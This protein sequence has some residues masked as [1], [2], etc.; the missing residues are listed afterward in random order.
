MDEI[1]T[2]ATDSA[3]PAETS[4]PVEGNVSSDVQQGSQSPE[5]GSPATPPSEFPS[6]EEFA[7][8]QASER[9]SNWQRARARIDELNAQNSE[10]QPLTGFLQQYGGQPTI[11]AKVGFVDKLWTPAL[12]DNGQPY[13]DPNTGV[14]ALTTQPFI[15]ELFSSSPQTGSQLAWELMDQQLQ[16]GQSVGAAWMQHRLGLDPSKYELYKQISDGT[17]SGPIGNVDQ[18]ELNAIAPEFHDAY[19]TWNDERRL[20]FWNSPE[21]VQSQLLAEGK[22]ALDAEKF[23][24]EQRNQQAQAE[25]QRAQQQ[26]QARQRLVEQRGNA[27][28][29]AAWQQSGEWFAQE[30]AKPIEMLGLDPEIKSDISQ[31]ISTKVEHTIGNDPKTAPIVAGITSNLKLAEEYASRGDKYRAQA[32]LTSAQ[33]AMLQLRPMALQVAKKH[34]EMANKMFSGNRAA[35]A[36]TN[37]TPARTEIA[38][39]GSSWA[40]E[41]FNPNKSE[42]H[43]RIADLVAEFANSGR[44]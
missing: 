27:R 32:S 21:S 7:Q 11:E 4:S 35:L 25:Q 13:V 15:Q 3:A 17:F 8:L 20:A 37:N 5:S 16:N 29:E 31:W 14:P 36:Q 23:I 42:R 28:V 40:K 19:K 24:Q 26:E 6:D 10:L 30:I 2:S 18:R 33:N 44:T 43:S 34:I 38:G 12:D 22:R 9:V 39:A 41:A 1:Q